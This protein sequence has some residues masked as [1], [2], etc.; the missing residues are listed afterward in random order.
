MKMHLS[1][2]AILTAI[3]FSSLAAVT[4]IDLDTDKDGFISVEEASTDEPLSNVFKGL[5]VDE[6][7]MLSSVEFED[8]E[9]SQESDVIK[10]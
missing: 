3:S 4:F 1:V 5:D 6:D 8:Y 10:E 7:G 2:F 9:L